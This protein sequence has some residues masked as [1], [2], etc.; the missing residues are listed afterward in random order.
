MR[1]HPVAHTDPATASTAGTSRAIAAES[2]S[3]NRDISLQFTAVDPDNLSQAGWG[4][5]QLGGIYSETMT[6]LHKDPL[7]IEGT[8]RLHRASRIGVLNDGLE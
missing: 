1:Q 8:F 4:D 2:S 6:G 3:V 5:N 7:R